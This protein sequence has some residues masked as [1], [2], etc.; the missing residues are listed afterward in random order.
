MGEDR[1]GSSQRAEGKLKKKDQRKPSR[2]RDG[3]VTKRASAERQVRWTAK[4]KRKQPKVGTEKQGK[5]E[6]REQQRQA[7]PQRRKPAVNHKPLGRL[8]KLF[9]RDGDSNLRFSFSA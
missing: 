7:L 6:H 2:K 8:E 3:K 4:A 5:V 9:R 1:A